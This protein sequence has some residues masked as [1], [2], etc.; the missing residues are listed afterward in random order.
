MRAVHVGV[1]MVHAAADS[2]VS[3]TNRTPS[4]AAAA[5]NRHKCALYGRCDY[6]QALK[7]VRFSMET[8]GHLGVPAM[9]LLGTLAS[10]AAASRCV[11][12]LTERALRLVSVAPARAT[13]AC[14][15]SRYRRSPNFMGACT[16]QARVPRPQET[17]SESGVVVASGMLRS[18]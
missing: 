18:G 5:W 9:R 10:H 6:A 12:K 1:P 13:A 3:A 4:A 2:F 17:S 16:A 8:Y 15:A 14:T 11:S 7:L